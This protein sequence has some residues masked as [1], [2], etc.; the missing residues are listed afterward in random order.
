MTI[1]Y[2]VEF[3]MHALGDAPTGYLPVQR[4]I[5]TRQTTAHDRNLVDMPAVLMVEDCDFKKIPGKI[6][7]TVL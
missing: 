7:R 2:P 4:V 3:G 1:L 6:Y 5:F